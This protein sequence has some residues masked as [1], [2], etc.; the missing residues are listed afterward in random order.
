MSTEADVV[1]EVKMRSVTVKLL[2][3]E[4]DLVM[5][6][7]V[8]KNLV[9]VIGLRVQGVAIALVRVPRDSF[10]FSLAQPCC[11]LEHSLNLN[12]LTNT[13][14]EDIFN[15]STIQSS[16]TFSRPYGAENLVDDSDFLWISREGPECPS[17]AK[18]LR[19]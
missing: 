15:N 19:G 16:S 7:V 14:R 18:L 17:A 3:P 1:Y 12:C 9:S 10:G 8:F 4:V 11:C 13:R 2:E 6:L 5:Q